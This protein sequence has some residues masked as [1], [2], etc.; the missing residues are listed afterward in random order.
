MKTGKPSAR[1]G[2]GVV[3]GG[4]APMGLY[5]C[6]PGGSNDYVTMFTSNRANNRQWHRLLEVIG[7]S[8]LIG[9]ERYET[10]RDG[11]E[12]KDE[13]NAIVGTMDDVALKAKAMSHRQRRRSLQRRLR[14]GGAQQESRLRTWDFQM[15]RPSYTRESKNARMARAHVRK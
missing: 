10:A 2:E 8:E 11:F 14:H 13:I 3:T 15:D 12:R 5:P 9:D 1:A 4:N 6:K 7:L